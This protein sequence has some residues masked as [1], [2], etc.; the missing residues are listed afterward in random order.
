MGCSKLAEE[1]RQ[2][3]SASAEK[4]TKVHVQKPQKIPITFLKRPIW[5]FPKQIT[6]AFV[7]P[8]CN[9]RTYAENGSNF[10]TLPHRTTP[11]RAATAPPAP[12]PL[13]T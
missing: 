12:L 10:N 9:L 11:P 3:F 8:L 2:I 1:G 4:R 5:F 7:K 13:T 6:C